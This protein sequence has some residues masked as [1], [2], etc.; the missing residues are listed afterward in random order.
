MRS[1]TLYLVSSALLCALS[2]IASA[3]L[4]AYWQGNGNALDSSGNGNNGVLENGVTY[5]PFLTGQAF[6][7]DGSDY[8]AAP[9]PSFNLGA[10]SSWTISAWANFSVFNLQA[11]YQLPNTLVAQDPNQQSPRWSFYFD[12]SANSLYWF[13]D[14]GATYNWV[15]ETLPTTVSTGAWNMFTIT[16]SGT[17]VSFYFNAQYLG[18]A[19]ANL[20]IAS[21]VGVP[22]TLGAAPPEQVTGAGGY[23]SGGQA[24]T[25]I[26]GSAL[27]Q[28]QIS[29]IYQAQSVPEP[30]TLGIAGLA[31]GISIFR[32]RL[33]SRDKR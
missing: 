12:E 28:T 7:F 22:I 30:S 17:D 21:I 5:Q 10:G 25:L 18:T 32:L 20:P 2:R 3:Q 16:G 27:S 14:L 23:W 15:G 31:A 9:N 8:V 11:F 1:R 26:Y 6:S 4:D 19:N 13:D 33:R 29:A 24:D